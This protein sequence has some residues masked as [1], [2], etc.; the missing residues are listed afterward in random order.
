MNTRLADRTLSSER[1][2]SPPPT[3]RRLRECN[4]IRL[5]FEGGQWIFTA[6]FLVL[7]LDWYALVF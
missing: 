3:P 5:P 2:L 6:L 7:S 4:M 1:L